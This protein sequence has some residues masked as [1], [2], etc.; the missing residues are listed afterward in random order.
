MALAL[1]EILFLGPA[2]YLRSGVHREGLLILTLAFAAQFRVPAE[3]STDRLLLALARA[4]SWLHLQCYFRVVG[5]IGPLTVTCRLVVVDVF[6][7]LVFFLSVHLGFSV[8]YSSVTDGP[9]ILQD[10]M[11]LA[12]L[13]FGYA[14][15]AELAEKRPGSGSQDPEV[16]PHE[17]RT[18][19]LAALI[20]E[21]VVL[22]NL[23]I[24]QLSTRF[25]EVHARAEA[26]V[27]FARAEYCFRA[28]LLFTRVCGCC[29]RRRG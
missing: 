7:F 19:L 3:T 25:A 26:E 9:G 6:W 21:A 17:A 4:G 2:G 15:Y 12:G 27:A 8:A 14:D 20:T 16:L 28:E 22:L 10:A 18:V 1:V 23:L 24:A 13:P 5:L 11:A 29:R